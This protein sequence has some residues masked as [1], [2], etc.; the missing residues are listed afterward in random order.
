MS[1]LANLLVYPGRRYAY[2]MRP[3][4]YLKINRG[5]KL[6]AVLK[7]GAPHEQLAIGRRGGPG[8]RTVSETS[9]TLPAVASRSS[10]LDAAEI[11]DFNWIKD[12]DF[13]THGTIEWNVQV[14]TKSSKDYRGRKGLIHNLRRRGKIN[15][16]D[17]CV[18][19]HDTGW[20][21]PGRGLLRGSVQ[22]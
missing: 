18:C 7:R 20:A 19:F 4:R 13:G 5:L 15:S 10:N 11:V 3:L 16:N 21:D 17:I 22:D 12:P 2:A 6:P 14:R 8:V 9:S 1:I